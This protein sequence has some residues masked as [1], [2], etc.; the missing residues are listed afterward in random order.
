LLG[1][2]RPYDCWGS[3]GPY[4]CWGSVGPYDCWGSVGPYDC[5][6][7]LGPYKPVSPQRSQRRRQR[8]NAPIAA[9][10]DPVGRASGTVV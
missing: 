3:V 5:W 10:C 8:G 9:L 4:D 6:G 7:S 2:G 1:L